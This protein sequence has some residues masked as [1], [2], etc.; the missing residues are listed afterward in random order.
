[1]RSARL[2]ERAG[3]PARAHGVTRPPP[4]ALR[5]ATAGAA[6]VGVSFGM[7]RYGYGLLLPDFRRDYGLG[8]GVLGAIGTGSYV[9]YLAATALTGAFAA[10]AG[11]RRT[12]V[13]GGLLAA[14]GMTVAGLSS[15]PGAFAAG[16]LVAGSSAG[17]V[18][19]PFSDAARS[20]APLPRARALAAINC[21]T[22]YGVALAAPIAMLAGMA[23]RSAW[24]AF[25]ALALL[26]T[27]W[28][29]RVLPRRQATTETAA[30][31]WNGVLCPRARRLLAGAVLLG[32]GSSAYWTFAVAHL[33]DAGG[34]SSSASRAFL[35][36]VG[37]A[38]VLATGTGDMVHRLG[39]RRA[40]TLLVA[41]EAAGVG[42]LAAAPSSTVAALASAIMFGA[43]YNAAVG[44]QALW[45]THLFAAR[46]S[47]GLSAAMGANGVGLLLGPVVA[48]A[49]TGA[50]GPSRPR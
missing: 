15:T 19:A 42:L 40:Y 17:L 13:A 4:S 34:F 3:L 41:S 50:A 18:F 49:A 47:L 6:M 1:V 5:L 28:A 30:T 16:I 26:A 27:W 21:G 10:R 45:S 23:W 14:A 9:G 37:V 11:A 25:A 29:A 35:G 2:H 31:G 22:S 44:V 46:P 8:P 33:V 32:I 20:L 12:A 7:A 38:G 48:G 39:A 43:A 36:V 24:L